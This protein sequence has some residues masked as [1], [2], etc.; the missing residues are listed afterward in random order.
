MLRTGNKVAAMNDQSAVKLE[1]TFAMVRDGG[2]QQDD[3][4]DVSMAFGGLNQLGN[5]ESAFGGVSALRE[6]PGDEM[7]DALVREDVPH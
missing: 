5:D 2:V 3:L 1:E 7:D 6:L 4:N